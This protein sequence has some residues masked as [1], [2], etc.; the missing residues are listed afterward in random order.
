M[1]PAEILREAMENMTSPTPWST[2]M[3]D[4]LVV[5]TD[6]DGELVCDLGSDNLDAEDPEEAPIKA[7]LHADADLIVTAVNSHISLLAA[8]KASLEELECFNRMPMASGTL[9]DV[10]SRLRAAISLAEQGDA[11]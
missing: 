5:I 8:A 7:R 2:W 4:D 3:Q 9:D 1:T 10:I 11:P 6:A